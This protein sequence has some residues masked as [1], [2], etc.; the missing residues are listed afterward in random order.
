ML[1]ELAERPAARHRTL[2]GQLVAELRPGPRHVQ[3]GGQARRRD[4][5]ARAR[6][7]ADRRPV[8]DVRADPLAGPAADGQGH[9]GDRRPR[10]RHRGPAQSRLRRRRWPGRAARPGAAAAGRRRRPVGRRPGRAAVDAGDGPARTTPATAGWSR[11]PSR[12]RAVKAWSRWCRRPPTG[13]STSSPTSEH[14]RRRRG[15]RRPA[16]RR[17]DRAHAR[18]ARPHA[19]PAARVGQRRRGHPRPVALLAAP[20]G[21]PQRHPPAATSGW[22]STSARS[23]ATPGDDLLSKLANLEGD[24]RLTDLELRATALLLLGAGFETTVNLIGNAV[25]LL[26]QHPD[27]LRAAPGG[28]VGLGQ[29]RRGGAALRLTGPGDHPPG[30]HA[31]PRS[32]ASACPRAS[33]S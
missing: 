8:P 21:R 6:P 25:R 14:V 1:R 10:A 30:L 19:P 22:T 11:A 3:A 7:A 31:T 18:R 9:P 12:S 20:Q 15:L 28:P 5:A 23:A 16:A 2:G 32:T 13:C 17:R 4:V 24:D 29:R 26:D 33:R 27:Q